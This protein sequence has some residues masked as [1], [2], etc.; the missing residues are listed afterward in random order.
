MLCLSRTIARIAVVGA[1]GVGVLAV[2]A[3]PA[4]IK[5]LFWQT[6]DSINNQIDKM[7]T[8]PV[9]LRQQLRDLEGQY[10]KKIA[11]VRADLTEVRSQLQQ[12]QREQQVSLRVVELADRDMGTLRTLVEQ[13]E[14]AA[15]AMPVSSDGG[16]RRIELVFDGQ[17]L[18]LEAAMTKV[19]DVSN[20]RTAY[21]TRL[22]DID[23]DMGH[24]TKQ[25]QRLAALL[26]KLE[27]ERAE[28]QVQL[29][30]LDRQVDSIAR[31]DRMIDMLTRRQASIEEHSRYQAGSLDH[32]TSRVTDIRARQ[33][34]ELAALSAGEDRTDYEVKAKQELDRES[35]RKPALPAPRTA[36]GGKDDVIRIHAKPGGAPAPTG[37]PSA[38]AEPTPEPKPVAAKPS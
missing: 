34:A 25:E 23:R 10:P 1:L 12:L 38:P 2:I 16:P 28:F 14:Q 5:A 3:G 7:I 8:D 19:T 35:S 21:A 33:E 32:I 15:A 17:P 11:Q 26:A 31:N 6:R 13:G 36:S 20:T 22:I 4:R 24:M 37:K 27:A 18:T 30:Q 29:W 9:A